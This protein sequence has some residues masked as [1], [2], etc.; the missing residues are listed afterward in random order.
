MALLGFVGGLL[1]MGIGMLGA[2]VFENH[3]SVHDFFVR[4]VAIGLGLWFIAAILGA[5]EILHAA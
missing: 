5:P 1:F 4:L 2:E 3:E